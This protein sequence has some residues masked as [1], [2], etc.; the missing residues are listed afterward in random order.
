MIVIPSK[1]SWFQ[2]LLRF[3][4]TVAL[5]IVARIL[6]TTILAAVLTFLHVQGYWALPS[7]TVLPFSF[8]GL[9]LSIFLGFRNSS[10]Y[11]RFYEGRKLWGLLVN[12][13]RSIARQTLTVPMADATDQGELKAWQQ[14]LIHLQI[15]Y[16]HALRCHLRG[17]AYESLRPLVS[18]ALYERM[19]VS[20]NSPMIVVQE[21][22]LRLRQARERGWISEYLVPQFEGMFN[23]LL[24]IQG[25]CER[26]K[27]TPIPF[28]YIVLLHRL[29]AI[30]CFALPFGIVG[31]VGHFTPFVVAIVSYAFM[32]LD[33]LGDSIENP[34][35]LEPHD[36]PLSALS[37]TIEVN[38]RELLE[39]DHGLTLSRPNEQWVLL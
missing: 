22:S 38:L 39:E 25:G 19:I 4:N 23:T 34:F 15:A 3:Q 2:I 10:A 20:S 13:S 11:D 27:A 29:V 26:I 24:D 8:V 18:A 9:A 37:R 32:G 17:D 21:M 28:G 1:L 16:V 7:L 30:Y 5:K 12:T 31:Q 6:T 33:A 14:Q 36:L 35:D